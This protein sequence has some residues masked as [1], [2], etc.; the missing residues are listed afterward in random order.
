MTATASPAPTNAA[1]AID[2]DATTRWTT[3]SSQQPGQYLSLDLG[4]AYTARRVVLDTGTDVTDFP[5]GYLL[6]TSADGMRWS[7]PVA[8]GAGQGQLT[9]I[10]L[11]AT[12]ARYLRVTQT[13]TAVQSWTVADL[14]VY[15]SA[16]AHRR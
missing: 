2:D 13:S 10:D 6:S 4:R 15:G 11:P 16:A 8:S 12:R 5:A 14:R 9:V 3:G 7:R 1:N